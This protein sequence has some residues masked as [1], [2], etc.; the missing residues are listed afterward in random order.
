[1]AWYN[2]KGKENDV[3]ISSRVRFAR[4]IKD[5]PFDSLL[6]ETSAKEIIEKVENALGKE[7]K[8]VDFSKCDQSL[9]GVYT[10]KHF[11]S[12]EFAHKKK[13]HA[14]FENENNTLEIMV[15]EE[16]HLR[17]QSIKSGLAL[18]EA[19]EEASYAEQLLDEKLN[20][21]FCEE[22]GYLTHCPT[23]LGTAMRVSVM[24]FLPALTSKGAINGLSRQLSKL[25]LIMRG[26]YGEG[27]SPDGCMYQI[28]NSVTMGITEEETLQKL[29]KISMQICDS[30]RKA[31]EEMKSDMY[32]RIYDKVCRAYGILKYSRM[33]SSSEFLTLFSDVRLGISL[34]MI[35]ELSYEKLG[36]I[37]IGILPSNLIYNSGNK[38]LSE[39]E[40]DV[41]RSEYVRNSL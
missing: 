2:E 32:D 30:E 8:K 1:M 29:R 9:C 6:D 5:Y 20:I 11:I 35:D 24:M 4:N 31:R 7:Y 26:M 22:L 27:S 37:L 40:R 10:E 25:G 12:P 34:G 28:S 23:N 18:E 39:N 14:L 17:I 41:K 15:C 3:F 13:P 38:P 21:A 36:E 19:F 33:M 16:D